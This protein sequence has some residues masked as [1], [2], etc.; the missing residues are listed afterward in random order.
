MA[1]DTGYNSFCA[2]VM[3]FCMPHIS[4]C[5]LKTTVLFLTIYPWKQQNF[6]EEPRA[7]EIV[8]SIG[9]LVW[10]ECKVRT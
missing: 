6:A 7:R 4:I 3:P 5:A 8:E 2:H 10:I 9:F 1:S